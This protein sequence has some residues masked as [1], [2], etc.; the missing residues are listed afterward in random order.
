MSSEPQDLTVTELIDIVVNSDHIQ[1]IIED[2]AI[3]IQQYL[4]ILKQSYIGTCVV[5]SF[6]YYLELKP[7]ILGILREQL[8]EKQ[9]EILNCF[10]GIIDSAVYDVFTIICD[11]D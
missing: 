8:S 4:D 10:S 3:N 5:R 9:A 11:S 7:S 1:Q 2:Y 6:S